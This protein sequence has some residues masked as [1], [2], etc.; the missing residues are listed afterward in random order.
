MSRKK[1]G[2]VQE[3]CDFWPELR[4]PGMS[5]YAALA[6]NDSPTRRRNED[7]CTGPVRPTVIPREGESSDLGRE[8]AL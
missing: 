2:V 8:G 7:G 5:F 1:A 3:Q 6:G 4:H